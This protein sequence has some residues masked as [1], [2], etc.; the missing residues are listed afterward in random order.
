M[1]QSR[2]KVIGQ[3]ERHARRLEGGVNLGGTSR[4]SDEGI[5]DS[6]LRIAVMPSTWKLPRKWCWEEKEGARVLIF[7][8]HREPSVETR[9]D[10]FGDGLWVISLDWSQEALEQA[11]YEMTF[12]YMAQVGKFVYEKKSLPAEWEYMTPEQAGC[13]A[14]KLM[15][16]H[17]ILRPLSKRQLRLAVRLYNVYG[18]GYPPAKDAEDVLWFEELS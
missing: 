3:I 18:F 4:T 14:V 13:N 1:R 6:P 8:E 5:V 12:W 10:S 15:L 2:N 11:A 7:P 16:H 9:T 17:I